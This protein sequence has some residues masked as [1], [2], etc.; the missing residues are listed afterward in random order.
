M[1]NRL[2][3]FKKRTLEVG[4][5]T[6]VASGVIGGSWAIYDLVTLKP[7]VEYLEE[8]KKQPDVLTMDAA[9]NCAD[10]KSTA[11]LRGMALFTIGGLGTVFI[12]RKY[13][14]YLS[15]SVQNGSFGGGSGH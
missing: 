10:Y 14:D 7:R 5:T 6:C 8:C 11:P 12:D 1:G 13:R 15:S 9:N 4:L 2:E 3:A